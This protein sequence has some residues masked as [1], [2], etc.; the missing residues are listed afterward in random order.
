LLAALPADAFVAA[1]H[2]GEKIMICAPS[3]DLIVC[4]YTNNVKDLDDSP[5]NTNTKCNQAARLIAQA[6]KE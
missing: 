2:G 4:W 1:G 5:A 3:W 6:V